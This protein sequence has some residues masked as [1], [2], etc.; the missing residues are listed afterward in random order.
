MRLTV[1]YLFP[2]A[3]AL[4]L[5]VAAMMGCTDKGTNDQYSGG[6]NIDLRARVN[7][8]SAVQQVD[9]FVLTV[10]A[11]DMDTVVDTLLFENGKIVGAI[12]VPVGTARK[13]V[14]EAFETPAVG[15]LPILIYKGVT[16]TDVLPGTVVTLTIDM[17]PVVPMVRLSPRY[18]E[19]ESGGVFKVDIEADNVQGLTA[20]NIVLDFNSFFYAITPL[21]VDRHPS[22]RS[23]VVVFGQEEYDGLHYRVYLSDS[24]FRPMVNSDGDGVLATVTF[25]TEGFVADTTIMGSISI[26]ELAMVDQNEDSIPLLDLTT[27]FA[28]LVLTS[29]TDRAINFPDSI[30]QD[31]VMRNVKVTVPPVY[32]SDVQYLN[33][34]D[35]AELGIAD[36]TGL[37]ELTNLQYLGLD[38]ND[39][40]DLAPLA[41]L[42]GLNYL[43]VQGNSVT[44]INPLAN[45]IGLATLNLYY[46]Q[47]SDIAPLSELDN[48]QALNLSNNLVVDLSPLSGLLLLNN[49]QLQY[50]N[51]SD[52]SPL[53]D[54]PGLG[55]G[56]TID[57]SGNPLD[58]TAQQ[59][60]M[61][62]LRQRGATVIYGT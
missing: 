4:V 40:P 62:T 39:A 38:W 17:D 33:S 30:L 47:I 28:E 50:N 48:L 19:M 61:D 29:Q 9:L 10:T 22:Q 13:F 6:G 54:N 56:D 20:M 42:V 5:L 35:L 59:L 60:M 46:N 21:K 55:T 11:R 45:L 31:A 14:L 27:D 52:I 24:Q 7:S 44:N 43:S 16:V 12:E 15:G 1:K 32:F 41:P 25:A 8:S 23:S 3:V 57:L 51:I 58:D 49:L 2:L 34:L 26:Y 36:W 37:G 53:L 18:T